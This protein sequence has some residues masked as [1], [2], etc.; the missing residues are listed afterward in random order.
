MKAVNGLTTI[1]K[2]SLTS[3]TN[4]LTLDIELQV[5]E[6]CFSRGMSVAYTT[7]YLVMAATTSFPVMV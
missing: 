2:F 3:I 5:D 6:I 7:P 1:L 4:H